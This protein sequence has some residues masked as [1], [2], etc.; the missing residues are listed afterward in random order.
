MGKPNGVNTCI[1]CSKD[2]GYVNPLAKLCNPV[3]EWV[4]C[5]DRKIS[6]IGKMLVGK[7]PVNREHELFEFLWKIEGRVLIDKTDPIGCST[8]TEF[9]LEL[10]DPNCKPV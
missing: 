9:T 6:R 1:A 10:K 8:T 5:V 3:R 4:D 2:I 7:V